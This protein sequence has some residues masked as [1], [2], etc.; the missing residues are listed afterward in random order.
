[1][2]ISDK[3]YL[4]KDIPPANPCLDCSLCIRLRMME[5]GIIPGTH[6]YL[7]KRGYLWTLHL[8]DANGLETST[9]GLRQNELDRI[10]LELVEK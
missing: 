10:Q 8:L 2:L 4:I 3:M 6:V 9:I 7:K 1:M 5:M